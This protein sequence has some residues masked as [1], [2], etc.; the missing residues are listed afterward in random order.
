MISIK[1]LMLGAA[2]T[3][4]MAAALAVPSAIAQ[5][6]ATTAAATTADKPAF[7]RDG[8]AKMFESFDTNKDGGIDLDEFLAR[9]KGKFK[10]IDTNNDEKISAE[11]LAA[12][13][14][15]K[16]A[17]MK[18][19]HE[20]RSGKSGLNKD[21]AAETPAVTETETTTTTTTKDTVTTG[22]TAE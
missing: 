14:D 10:E 18:E 3:G 5:N 1:T 8:G 6:A 2:M 12:H 21:Q 22:E 15:K 13:G 19:F 7:K 20:K 11:E 17:K 4:M 16:R 9:H